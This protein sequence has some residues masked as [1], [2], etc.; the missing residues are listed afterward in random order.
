MN[1]TF[2]DEWELKRLAETYAFAM[3]RR[4][5][6]MLKP[7][8]TDDA[9]IESIFRAQRGIAE[10]LGIPDLL[11]KMYA[12]TLHA[13]HNQRVVITG[14]TAEGE[15]YCIAYHMK[16][17]KDGKNMRFDYGLK[18]Q[19]SFRRV[20]GAWRFSRRYLKIEWTQL[21]EV[22]IPAAPAT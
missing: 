18:Y 19:D 10:I 5:P 11:T 8:F 9:V 6:E 2:K 14:D 21:S 16:H 4:D 15:T 12:A 1:D 22:Q 13:V 3:D 17:P 20:N 7:L